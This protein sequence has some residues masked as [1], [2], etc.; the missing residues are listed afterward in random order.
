MVPHKEVL[1]KGRDK[2]VAERK[3]KR[4]GRKERERAEQRG[5]ILLIYMENGGKQVRVGGK[6]NGF[7]NM[8]AVGLANGLQVSGQVA[9]LVVAS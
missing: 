9:G 7:W 6:T 3:G 1:L 8:V 4:R 5:G 2:G